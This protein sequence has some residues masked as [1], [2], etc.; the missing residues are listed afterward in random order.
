MKKLIITILFITFIFYIKSQNNTNSDFE[1]ISCNHQIVQSKD[2]KLS[3][4]LYKNNSKDTIGINP[5]L[6]CLSESLLLGSISPGLYLYYDHK[7]DYKEYIQEVL[8][9]PS[10]S[11]ISNTHE[12]SID[13]IHPD[14]LGVITQV[15]FIDS[16]NSKIWITTENGNLVVLTENDKFKVGHIG[17][18]DDLVSKMKVKKVKSFTYKNTLFFCDFLSQLELY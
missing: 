18:M 10:K 13:S 4:Y 9:D 15:I 17:T 5:L 8:N 7:I 6:N 3:A 1:N 14:L 11:V 16:L 12:I 2:S